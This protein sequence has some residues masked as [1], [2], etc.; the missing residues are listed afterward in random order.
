[1]AFLIVYNFNTPDKF[2]VFHK[3]NTKKISA[4]GCILLLIFFICSIIIIKPTFK[5]SRVNKPLFI[6]IILN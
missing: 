4:K 3:V 1:M 5:F 2:K 6:G